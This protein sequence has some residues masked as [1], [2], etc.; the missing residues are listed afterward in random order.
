MN[1]VRLW[2]EKKGLTIYTS[3]LDMNRCFTRAVRMAGIPLWYT[4]GFNPHPYMTF[5]LPLPLGTVGVREP[6]DIRTEQDMPKE[7][8]MARLNAVLPDGI[9]IVDV[10][11]PVNKVNEIVS[12]RYIVD[13]VFSNEGEAEGFAA[14]VNAVM[15]SGEL[16]AEKRSK[17]GIKTVN[18]C[19][20]VSSFSA[21]SEGVNVSINTV[22]AT[23]TQVNLNATLL[24]DTLCNEFGADPE[25]I[26]ITRTD[27][28]MP[29]SRNFE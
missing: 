13:I 20:M 18:L 27:I 10:T 5:L 17:R 24:V 19:E 14:G 3:H 7:E 12:A 16:M 6:I 22:L 4:E 26:R 21:E 29:E 2:Y 11:D 8:I 23:G 28:Y 1:S 9:K 25:K 15:E